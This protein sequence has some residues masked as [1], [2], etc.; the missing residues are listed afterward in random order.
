MCHLKETQHSEYLRT[1]SKKEGQKHS[2]K[3]NLETYISPTFGGIPDSDMMFRAPRVLK[4][5][6]YFVKP[7]AVY[8]LGQIYVREAEINPSH[9][10]RDFSLIS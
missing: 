7:V 9:L 10:R 6:V 8:K 4:G 5:V 2:Q 3:E 1:G